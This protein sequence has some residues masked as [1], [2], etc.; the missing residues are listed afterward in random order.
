MK[1][2][3]G[4]ISKNERNKSIKY[5]ALVL[6]SF[7][8]IAIDW[9]LIFGVVGNVIPLGQPAFDVAMATFFI[10][11]INRIPIF[12]LTPAI[13]QRVKDNRQ[14]RLIN[15][16]MDRT[17]NGLIGLALVVFLVFA[18]AF[19]VMSVSYPERFLERAGGTGGG[20]LPQPRILTEQQSILAS[21]IAGLLPM[22]TTTV[23]FVF[24]FLIER[25]NKEGL[26]KSEENALFGRINE[27]QEEAVEIDGEIILLRNLSDY[28]TNINQHIENFANNKATFLDRSK[29]EQELGKNSANAALSKHCLMELNVFFEHGRKKFDSFARTPEG[30]K[31]LEKWEAFVET[32]KADLLNEIT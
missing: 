8:L 21:W 11:V 25:D 23:V 6:A 16:T 17:G 27:L 9:Y 3:K 14:K 22:L 24:H 30:R 31:R 26:L 28:I 4:D 1:S 18:I 32:I 29:K 7:I 15:V 10:I 5:V 2:K 20:L 12:S 13:I 19:L